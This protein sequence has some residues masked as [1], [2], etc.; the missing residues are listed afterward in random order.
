MLLNSM[1]LNS[2]LQNR[3]AHQLVQAQVQQLQ[4]RYPPHIRREPSL[5]GGTMCMGNAELDM[6]EGMHIKASGSEHF[7]PPHARLNSDAG[8]Q[9]F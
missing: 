5:C 4:A 1:L 2:M 9:S 6:Q 8:M 3:H 7:S